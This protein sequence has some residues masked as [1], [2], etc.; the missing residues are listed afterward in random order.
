VYPEF[1]QKNGLLSMPA[2]IP[3]QCSY[4]RVGGGSLNFS[5][6]GRAPAY[7]TITLFADG[8]GAAEQ[9]VT[10]EK[11]MSGPKSNEPMI[12]CYGDVRLDAKGGAVVK[13]V[14]K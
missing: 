14:L 11:V 4:K 5:I 8:G 13:V 10:C 2:S 1:K 6:P 7:N 9:Q 12:M 3:S